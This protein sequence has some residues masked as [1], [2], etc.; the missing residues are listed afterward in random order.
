MNHKF[1]LK[2][3]SI[4]SH[5]NH[6]KYWKMKFKMRDGKVG[7][8]KSYIYAYKMKRMEAY[9]CAAL[10]TRPGG[11]SYF[12]GMPHLPHGIKGIFVSDYV[13]IGEKCT[14]FHQVT[15]GIKDYDHGLDKVPIIGDN[16]IIGAGA[17]VL[18]PIK[19]G[20]N[21]KIGANAVVTKDVPSGA[22]V[23]GNPG[24]IILK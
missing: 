1:M 8:I 20:D 3:N 14:I 2:I 11:G 13:R 23:V 6:E 4:L 19:I 22:T 12:K 9:N 18:G 5:Y 21:V 16:V 7:K 24:Q 15:I 17:K 10:G